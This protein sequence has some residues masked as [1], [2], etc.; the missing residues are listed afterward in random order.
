MK[1]HSCQLITYLFTLF[2]IY[3][4]TKLGGVQEFRVDPSV[5]NLNLCAKLLVGN[6]LE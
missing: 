1:W 3:P 6:E 4:D 5:F 2:K